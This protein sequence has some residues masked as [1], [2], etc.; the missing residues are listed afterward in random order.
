MAKVV[1]QKDEDISSLL[2]RFK[3]MVA[4]EEILFE[5]RK[6]EFFVK[7]PLA[8]KEKEKRAMIRNKKKM[9]KNKK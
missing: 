6:R 8:R 9:K 4:S 7:K 5:V 3:R 2:R 1:R